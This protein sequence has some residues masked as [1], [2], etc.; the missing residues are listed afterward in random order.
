MNRKE[1]KEQEIKFLAGESKKNPDFF[2]RETYLD[3]AQFLEKIGIFLPDK[4]QKNIFPGYLKL[5]PQDFIVEEVSKD[6]SFQTVGGDNSYKAED[7]EKQSTI[8]AT[9]VKCGL[10][11]IEAIEEIASFLNTDKKNIQFAGIKDKDALTAQLISFRGIDRAAIEK[12]YSPYFFLKDIHYGKGV[13][14][15]GGLAGNQFTI[16]IRTDESFEKENFLE[17]L[18]L[19][20]KNGFFN[21]FY[22]QRFSNPR[23][24][25]W[26]WGLLILKGEY[27]NAVFSL[28]C[29]EGQ[30]EVPYFKKLRQDLKTNFGNWQA[31]G[32]IL[33]SLPL[34][35]QNEIK[36]VDYLKKNPT[37]FAGALNQVPEQVQLWIYAYGSL[38]FN[39]KIS[40]HL[41]EEKP[42]PEKLPLI[43]SQDKNDWVQY[44]DFLIED[45][46]TTIPFEELRPFRFIQFKKRAVKTKE[47]VDIHN[48]AFI[49]E[50]VALSFTLGKGCYATT[51]LSHLFQLIGGLPPSTISDIKVDSKALLGEGNVQDILEKFKEVISSKKEDLYS[52]FV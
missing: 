33:E 23:F 50:G 18:E 52:K 1:A 9:L 51:F 37:D 38:L 28:L 36:M 22:S 3:D 21:F 24:I 27:K 42:L 47:M 41:R 13:M 17:T 34:S 4:I 29:S 32:N 8:Y 26:F 6:G 16:F 15:V 25:N 7:N 31:V 48:V 14:Q 19:I 20:K 49:K 45:G 35:F 44:N 12:I 2:K 46:I 30:R 43:L 11:T 10:S 40:E 39:R 5:W